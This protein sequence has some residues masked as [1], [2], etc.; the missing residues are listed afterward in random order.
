[1]KTDNTLKLFSKLMASAHDLINEE[2]VLLGHGA[3]APSHGEILIALYCSDTLSM[4]EIA[5]K[6]HRTPSTVTTLVNKLIALGYVASTRCSKD[7]RSIM[8]SLTQ[9]GRELQPDFWAISA[10]I[11]QKYYAGFTPEEYQIFRL[12][13]EKMYNQVCENNSISN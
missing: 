6:I 13:L 8:V 4:Q 9:R 11:Y 12:L 1:M 5:A 7:S 2:L 3:I 10:K